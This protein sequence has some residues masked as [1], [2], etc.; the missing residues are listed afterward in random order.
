MTKRPSEAP[1]AKK[2]IASPEAVELGKR[3]VRLREAKE[4][5]RARAAR[6][7]QIAYARLQKYEEGKREPPLWALIQ[8]ADGYRVSISFLVA[9]RQDEPKIVELRPHAGR[10]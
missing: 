3:L 4:W 1:P 9:G 6:E 8:M 5:N 2:I 7:L 10:R